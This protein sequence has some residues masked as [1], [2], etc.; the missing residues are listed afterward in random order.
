MKYEKKK[1]SIKFNLEIQYFQ[2]V[3][4]FLF[5]AR[6]MCKNIGKNISNIISDKY[7]LKFLEHPK[8]TVTDALKTTL[9][10]LIQKIE[11]RTSHLISNKT[12]DKVAKLY[13]HR[14]AK[15][16]K[17]YQ[18]NNSKTFTDE[19]DKEIPQERMSYKSNVISKN[20]KFVR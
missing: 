14:I 15:T 11:E 18:Q 12:A 13:D 9:K 19:Y 1:C 3:T 2:K 16:S 8:Q 5:F 20:N 7:S 10:R 6:D 4:N 17:A